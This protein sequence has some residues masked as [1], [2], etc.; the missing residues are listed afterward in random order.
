MLKSDLSS[1]AMKSRDERLN[2]SQNIN[3]HVDRPVSDSAL[4]KQ[5]KRERRMCFALFIV[6]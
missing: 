1:Y 3:P 2:D 6:S 5:D 4:F